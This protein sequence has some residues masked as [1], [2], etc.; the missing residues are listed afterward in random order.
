[1]IWIDETDPS[2]TY[3]NVADPSFRHLLGNERNKTT[4]IVLGDYVRIGG[5]AKSDASDPSSS[6]SDVSD[7]S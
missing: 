5:L 3:T 2:N 1:M 6:W 7:P 4:R